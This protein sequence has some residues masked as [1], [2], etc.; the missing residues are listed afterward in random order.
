MNL[1]VLNTKPYIIAIVF[2]SWP[3]SGILVFLEDKLA[4]ERNQIGIVRVDRFKGKETNRTIMLMDRKLFNEAIED[5]LDKNKKSVDFKI[6]EYQLRPHNYPKSGYSSNLYIPL[7]DKIS[8]D[9]ASRQIQKKIDI[10]VKFGLLTKGQARLNIPLK[11]R[12]TGVH[13][14]KAYITFNKDVPNNIPPSIKIILNDT[15]LYLDDET[16]NELMICYW[17]IDKKRTKFKKGKRNN[18]KYEMKSPI[19][20][21]DSNS[22]SNNNISTSTES[23]SY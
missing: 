6:A 10:C 19:K 3:L 14:G 23:E 17:A 9:N 15:R 11:S 22:S 12:E 5:G 18:R 4:A 20:L 21:T 7:P 8:S 13:N 1:L 2:S 16:S